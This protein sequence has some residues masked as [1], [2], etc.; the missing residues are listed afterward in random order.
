LLFDYALG[1]APAALAL[2]IFAAAASIAGLGMLVAVFARNEGQADAFPSLVVTAMAVV[3]GSMFPSIRVPGLEM[4]TPHYWAIRAMQAITVQGEGMAAVL[5]H[6][7]VLLS[8]AAVAFA[9]AA[10]RF[11]Q[12]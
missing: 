7:A 12:E 5:P 1:N 4:V 10:W 6:V 3:S 8:I 11:G 9:V 2:V